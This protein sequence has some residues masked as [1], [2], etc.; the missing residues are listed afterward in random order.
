M[1]K[2]GVNCLPSSSSQLFCR[3]KFAGALISKS[4]KAIRPYSVYL[5]EYFC[6]RDLHQLSAQG[7]GGRIGPFVRRSDGTLWC[8]PRLHGCG[9]D[10]AVTR[11]QESGSKPEGGCNNAAAAGLEGAL[12]DQVSRELAF[13][14]GPI[15]ELVVKR[16]ASRCSSPVELC[17]L[18]A[19]EIDAGADRA[20]FLASCRH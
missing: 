7:Y 18:V 2:T 6:G 9:C 4:G 16:A 17:G 3:E 19:E 15:A 20:R 11:L 12:L 14:I 1:P 13:Y 5:Q 10:S 8:S